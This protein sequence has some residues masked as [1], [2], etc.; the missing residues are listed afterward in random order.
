MHSVK[1]PSE[2]HESAEEQPKPK[3]KK[4]PVK[5]KG[6]VSTAKKAPAKPKA[7]TAPKAK[8]AAAIKPEKPNFE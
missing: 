6:T 7:A 3:A 8:K 2:E 4:A 5:S 1:T